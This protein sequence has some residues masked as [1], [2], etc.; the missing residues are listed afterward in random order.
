MQLLYVFILTFQFF[1]DS[2]FLIECFSQLGSR[3]MKFVAA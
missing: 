1:S 2:N 3:A